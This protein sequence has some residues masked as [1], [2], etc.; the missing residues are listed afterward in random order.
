MV[1]VHDAHL[2]IIAQLDGISGGRLKRQSSP[3]HDSIENW[4][5]GHTEFENDKKTVNHQKK[6]CMS[7]FWIVEMRGHTYTHKGSFVQIHKNS[8]YRLG[9]TGSVGGY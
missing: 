6:V 5:E 1:I 2:F 3:K 7:Q 9:F 4:L 8:D